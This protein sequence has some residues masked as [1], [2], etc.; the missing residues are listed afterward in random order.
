VADSGRRVEHRVLDLPGRQG[1]L[2][3]VADEH[4][5][6]GGP[7]LARAP[8]SNGPAHMGRSADRRLGRGGPRRGAGRP[9]RGDGS[10]PESGWGPSRGVQCRE[11]PEMTDRGRQGWPFRRR[12]P[13]RL[14]A[15]RGPAG[16]LRRDRGRAVPA[17][18]GSCARTPA[19]PPASR[20]PS[21]PRGC[22]PGWPRA[23]RRPRRS[24][25]RSTC[26]AGPRPGATGARSSSCWPPG[27]RRGHRHLHPAAADRAGRRG[28]GGPGGG[29][30]GRA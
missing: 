18:R 22:G 8:G 15:Y 21:C 20:W 24:P 1:Q 5:R 28:P 12:V 16:R 9:M 19:W 29:G 7:C 11:R 23:C 25:T 3:V 10:R 26:R 17:G 14:V 30:H 4:T 27:G 13:G 2:H 6:Q